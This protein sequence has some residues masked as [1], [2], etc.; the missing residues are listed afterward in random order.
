MVYDVQM[1]A[2]LS[3]FRH[4]NLIYSIFFIFIFRFCRLRIRLRIFFCFQYKMAWGNC[5]CV[6]VCMCISTQQHIFSIGIY[7]FS[8]PSCN[9]R[10]FF[11]ILLGCSLSLPLC[12][13]TISKEH[14]AFHFDRNPTDSTTMRQR[15]RGR[16]RVDAVV[17]K[18]R[19][20][21]S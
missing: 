7:V 17:G 8:L 14:C 6:C 11:C 4:K 5:V 12:C 10:N 15:T 18:K 16:Q 13:W 21:V 3:T 2:P 20:K 9:S 1:N 19:R